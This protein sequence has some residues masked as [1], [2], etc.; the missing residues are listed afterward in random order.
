MVAI[1]KLVSA[2]IE[3]FR[4][5]LSKEKLQE[6]AEDVEEVKDVVEDVIEVVDAA[7]QVI[8]ALP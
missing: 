8:D 5:C 3:L 7:K 2:V 4:K 1:G 6:I